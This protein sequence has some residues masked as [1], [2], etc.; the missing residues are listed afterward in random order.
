MSNNNNVTAKTWLDAA[1]IAAKK[2]L[3]DRL[4][5]TNASTKPIALHY[6]DDIFEVIG[7]HLIYKFNSEN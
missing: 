5:D 7:A 2:C 4:A 1:V 6:R 3:E